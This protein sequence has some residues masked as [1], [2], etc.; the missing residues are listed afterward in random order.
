MSQIIPLSP[1]DHVF[2][3][4]GS[5]PIEFI[6]YYPGILDE[7]QLRKSLEESLLYFPVISSRLI[8]ISEWSFGL[9]TTR[10]GY[11]F[12]TVHSSEDF[13][14]SNKEFLF[15][16]PV[17]SIE[18]EPLA[19][20][21]LTYTP[22]GS[23]LGVS[24]SHAVGDGFSYFHFLSSWAKLFH[25]Q[26]IILPD[27]S[28]N[29]L[30][31]SITGSQRKISKNEILNDTGLFLE[32][33]RKAYSRE[34][35]KWD[36]RKFPDEELK[37]MVGQV[38]KAGNSRLSVN[39]VLTAVL[40]KEYILKWMAPGDPAQTYISCPVDFRRI[41]PG[42]PKTYF[43]NA[44][45]MATSSL[46]HDVLRETG[47]SELSDRI[48]SIVAEVKPGYINKAVESLELIR[49]QEGLDIVERIH[50]SHPQSGLI[51][52]NLSRL[53]LQEIVFNCGPPVSYNILTS[54]VRGAV[55]LPGTG[56]LEVRICYPQ[57][58]AES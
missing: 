48:R 38:Q 28:R 40:W 1:I 41:L 17:E 9:E 36:I 25:G 32:G 22:S 2:T 47:I 29:I 35:L 3:G 12:E 45:V 42:F 44:V 16:D 34:K 46:D 4:T 19:R 18:N 24:I 27:H 52:T 6:F 26:Q 39:D 8:K 57:S 21:R 55:I 7:G 50:V 37:A 58:S 33:K 51:V 43:G 20:F 54:A 49:N 23:V 5:Y 31:P 56:G 14:E 53:P 30:I 10:N 13:Q 11:V 15:I